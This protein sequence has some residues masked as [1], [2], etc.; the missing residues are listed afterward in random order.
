VTLAPE[1]KLERQA[2]GEPLA[3]TEFIVSYRNIYNEEQSL[4]KKKLTWFSS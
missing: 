3:K 2:I 4:N 1:Q